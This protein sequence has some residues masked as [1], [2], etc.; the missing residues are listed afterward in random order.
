VSEAVPPHP[1]GGDLAGLEVELTY[2]D[3]SRYLGVSVFE[4]RDGK[5]V[6][7][8]DYYA[9]PFQAPDWRAAWVERT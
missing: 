8:T 2:A 7:E 1:G 5:V 3:G 6:K 9:Q 4:L